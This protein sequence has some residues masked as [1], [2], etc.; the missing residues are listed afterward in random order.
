MEKLT[1][2][3]TNAAV[4]SAFETALSAA[5]PRAAVAQIGTN[6]T[7]RTNRYTGALG[8]GFEVLAVL[9]LGWRELVITKQHGPETWREQPSPTLESLVAE[10]QQKRAA[11]YE[12]EASVFDLADAEAK[13]VSSDPEVQAEGA[14]QK[15]AVLAQ[16]LQIKSEL[17]KPL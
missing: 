8:S 9:N 14:I 3:Q 13:L 15:T 1:L 5:D 10:C 6:A 12:A 2:N 7:L 4:L 17:P 11:R 16:R